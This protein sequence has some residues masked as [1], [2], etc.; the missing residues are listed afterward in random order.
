MILIDNQF[1]QRKQGTFLFSL[2][3][4]W[5]QLLLRKNAYFFSSVWEG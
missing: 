1:M 4:F 2:L 5:A 3:Q